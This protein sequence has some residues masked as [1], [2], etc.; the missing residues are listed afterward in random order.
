MSDE[1]VPDIDLGADHFLVFTCWKPDRS[2]NPQYAHLPDVEKWGAII[3]HYKPDG[4][5]C[6]GCITFDGPVQRELCPERSKWK[7]WEFEPLTISPSLLCACGDH[8]FIKFGKWE[9]A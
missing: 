8:G 2:L 7:V 5:L 9:R 3:R 1:M 6:E 4:K